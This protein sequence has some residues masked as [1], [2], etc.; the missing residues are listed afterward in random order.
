MV[1]AGSEI[2]YLTVSHVGEQIATVKPRLHQRVQNWF[3][4]YIFSWWLSAAAVIFTFL[5][6]VYFGNPV[7]KLILPV[8]LTI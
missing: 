5:M 4:C 2:E 6:A 3:A 1:I 7:I 8:M